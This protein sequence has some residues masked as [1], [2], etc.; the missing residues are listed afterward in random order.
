LDNAAAILA[1]FKVPE[2]EQCD[3]A[4]VQRLKNDIVE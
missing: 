3:A 4:F 1:K 2:S